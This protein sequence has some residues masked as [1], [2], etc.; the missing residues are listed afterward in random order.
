M[1]P[2]NSTLDVGDGTVNEKKSSSALTVPSGETG[3]PI[4]KQ[5]LR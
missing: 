4:K 5:S 3:F 1:E 2:S